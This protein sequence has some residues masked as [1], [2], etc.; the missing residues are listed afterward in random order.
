MYQ[1]G[2]VIVVPFPF[3]DLSS[4]KIRP[5]IIISNNEKIKDTGDLIIVMITTKPKLDGINILIE[6]Q[7]VSIALPSES[8]VR[9]HRVATI[10]IKII[11]KKISEI[12]SSLKSKILASVVSFIEE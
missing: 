4:V 9:C 6:K 5:A 7:D 8:Y 11:Q 10:D 12:S 2:D 1:Q 3:T